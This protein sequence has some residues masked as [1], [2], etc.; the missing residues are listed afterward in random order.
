MS[1]GGTCG[2][3]T[4]RSGC[5]KGRGFK[6]TALTTLKMAVL[7]P[8][9]TASTMTAAAVKPGLLARPRRPWRMS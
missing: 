3:E 9:P 1:W 5:G 2:T 4:S 7:A 6:R 8:I